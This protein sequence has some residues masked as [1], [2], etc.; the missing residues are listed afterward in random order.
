MQDI[1]PGSICHSSAV[2][3][4]PLSFV[5]ALLDPLTPQQFAIDFGYLFEL[6]LHLVV[7]LDPAA[8]FRH[9]LLGDDATCGTATSQ[10]NG[11]RYQIG[12]CRSPLAHLQAGFPQVTYRSTSDP[13]R[14]SVTGGSSL[15][16]P[17]RRW[18]RASGESRANPLL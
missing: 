18:R 4:L 14:I 15:A 16:K 17:W 2:H 1:S 3:P 11:Q 8:D 12:P 10:S 5:L 6:I 13:R 7:V 9:F